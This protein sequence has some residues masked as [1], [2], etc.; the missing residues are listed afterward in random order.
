MRAES[1]STLRSAKEAASHAP[2]WRRSLWFKI[3]V[4]ALLP[5]AAVLGTAATLSLREWRNVT[6]TSYDV[7]NAKV[8]LAAVEAITALAIEHHQFLR[9]VDLTHTERSERNASMNLADDALNK[10]RRVTAENSSRNVELLK[11][12]DEISALHR[13]IEARLVLSPTLEGATIEAHDN[14]VTRLIS[15]ALID[16]PHGASIDVLS[17]HTR[18]V[19]LLRLWRP[20]LIETEA[21]AA[22][23]G[24]PT[25]Q[26]FAVAASRGK[27]FTTLMRM[28]VPDE[29]LDPSLGVT[30]DERSNFRRIYA[31]I[32]ENS[33][34]S[35]TG[36]SR[37]WKAVEAERLDGLIAMTAD[38]AAKYQDDVRAANEN[39][40]S[41]F[42]GLLVGL[43][44]ILVATWGITIG[45]ARSI[46]TRVNAL[47]R[48]AHDII[49]GR[50][51]VDTPPVEVDELDEVGA[52]FNEVAT[53]IDAFR[54]EAERLS[55]ALVAGQTAARADSTIFLG[56]WGRLVDGLNRVM[57]RHEE[58]LDSMLI[59]AEQRAVLSH[60]AQAALDDESLIQIIEM[61]GERVLN[62]AGCVALEL[63][64]VVG[65]STV[66]LRWS[67]Q[68]RDFG[69]ER[70]RR[71]VIADF[72]QF[73]P[74]AT[75]PLAGCSSAI[76]ATIWGRT[77]ASGL[78]V[79]WDPDPQLEPERFIAQV[80]QMYST[81]AMREE[82]DRQAIYNQL[83]DAT[84]G[85][86]NSLSVES[87]L[88]SCLE[89]RGEG[90]VTVVIFQA[91]FSD[92]FHPQP[93]RLSALGA[94]AARLRSRSEP[95]WTV[96]MAGAN[97][98]CLVVP[99]RLDISGLAGAW[100]N[101]VRPKVLAH[102][103]PVQLWIGV[104]S[105]ADVTD[106]TVTGMLVAAQQAARSAQKRRLQVVRYDPEFG[107]EMTRHQQVRRRLE[108][109][110]EQGLNAPIHIV[111]QPIV[112]LH[113]R[114]VSGF[115]SLA[116][117]NPTDLGPQRPD[118][119][120]PMAEEMGLITELG[121]V[122]ARRAMRDKLWLRRPDLSLA[123]NVS[124]MD[125]IV[126]GHARKLLDIAREEGIDP[127]SLRIELTETA[128]VDGLADPIRR[129]M[130]ELRAAGCAISIDDFGTG[131][132]SYAYLTDFP[133]Q[134]VK[135]DRS[136]IANIH[137]RP[138]ARAVVRSVIELAHQL[139]LSVVAEGVESTEELGVV[140]ELGCDLVQ[141]YVFCRPLPVAEIASALVELESRIPMLI[142][143]AQGSYA[144][145]LSLN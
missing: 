102:G 17:S 74:L 27:D 84:T 131:H 115:E 113:T 118:Q 91:E 12:L 5:G 103:V 132:A 70:P 65:E 135:I 8:D 64:E 99:G 32:T 18:L 19:A 20:Y 78:V 111:L 85:L 112:S 51:G 82:A 36:A 97:Q 47:S 62:S 2:A 31:H 116:R 72:D 57:E 141:G 56:E 122:L 23:L 94:I 50:F 21:I 11:S 38:Y 60:I 22:Y 104:A 33:V 37:D 130:G 136:F 124:A 42:V 109:D 49:E 25:P 83:H 139:D 73:D 86:P 10:L 120:I 92:E 128:M 14:L 3:M 7:A 134:K 87:I 15:T 34:I 140:I 41:T 61:S 142:A 77:G 35:L 40:R 129:E 43:A 100:P 63:W 89:Q 105:T 16:D 95:T 88:S 29:N 133:V 98:I 90:E 114:T 101:G 44:L 58:V 24:Q 59:E 54:S 106:P 138:E 125:M 67:L 80:G 4:I 46:I 13:A 144:P 127:N 96:G 123:I 1:T 28:M 71:V 137:L 6:A 145:A 143:A 107:E 79:A 69:S 39:A 110:I 121:L 55:V 26:R 66:A 76:S 126:L 48:N 30:G 68:T 81:I 45:V 93:G 9:Y 108:L 119:F 53:R 75:I 117:W 52:A